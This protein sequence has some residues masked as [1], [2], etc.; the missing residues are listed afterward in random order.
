MAPPMT[1][2]LFAP[3]RRALVVGLILTITLVASE[4]LAVGT[5]MPLVA[6][7]LGG[8]ELYGWA[9]SAFFLGQLIGIVVTGG[10]LDRG[11]PRIP[12]A[13][14]L[15][16]FGLGLLVGGLAPTMPVL[17]F[18]RFLQGL[19]AGAM[20]PTAYVTIGRSFPES[21]R[22]R[23]FALLSTAWVVPGVIGPSVAAVVAEVLDW[24]WIFLGL[25]PFVAAAGLLT[26][27][28][29]RAVPDAPPAEAEAARS[30]ARRIPLALAVA[31]GAAL[32]L[33]GLTAAGAGEVV[34]VAGGL[35][36]AALGLGVLVP[37]FRAL[38]P[39]GTLR[40]APG[41]PAT[42]LL[43]GV[44]TFAFVAADAYVPYL[45]VEARG[46]EAWTGGLAYTAATL[47]WTSGSWI[48]ARL[49]TR[50]TTRRF[51]GLGFLVL[52]AGTAITLVVVLPG[53]SWPL[54]VI[55]W[56]VAGLGMGLAYSPLSLA[57]LRDA[58]PAEQGS[59]TSAL[60]LSDTL[61]FTLGAG[62]AGAIVGAAERWVAGG[63]GPPDASGA[64]LGIVGAYVLAML[65]AAAGRL[66][67][68]RLPDRPTAAR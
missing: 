65:V 17:V 29:M 44:L 54:A 56:G 40:L 62:V 66:A 50:W 45:L 58:S 26:L 9:F 32:A 23:M 27:H 37:A 16:L 31:A 43:R 47:T 7:D 36:V 57:V 18:G 39:P 46:L 64:A 13:V 63:G 20:P 38:S 19:G 28:A 51:V 3:G 33:A 12:L 34:T 68:A 1:D 5:V 48:Q 30:T 14:G 2:G 24:R 52:L 15:V 41:L 6:A 4:S 61:G 8:I 21:V 49:A 42:I 25:L 11:S 22:P 35:A 60:Q 67:S 55:G 59:A 10:R 53:V